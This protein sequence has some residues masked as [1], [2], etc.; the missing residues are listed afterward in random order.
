MYGKIEISIIEGKYRRKQELQYQF[1]SGREERV[2][3]YI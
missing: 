1:F 3:E 2:E